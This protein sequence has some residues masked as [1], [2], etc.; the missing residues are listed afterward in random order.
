[1]NSGEIKLEIRVDDK[2]I[3]TVTNFAQKTGKEM[4]ELGNK[5][6]K[7]AGG[8]F[9]A[10]GTRAAQTLKTMSGGLR[11]AGAVAGKVA[12]K[13]GKIGLGITAAFGAATGKAIQ[14]AI[15][16]FAGFESAMANASTLVDTAKVSMEGL[17][18]GIME[19]PPSLG[20]ATQNAEA[21]YQALSAG[22]AP[23]ES[24]KF[25]GEAAKAAKAGLTDTFT[26]VDA[27]TTV[28]NAFGMQSENAGNIFDQMFKTVEQG[29]T[30]F[31]ELS[32]TIGRL[33]P[34]ASAASVSTEEMFAS[35]ATLTKGG[36]ATSEAV[37][38][39]STALGAV[40]KPSKEASDLSEK[41]GLNFSAT[42]LK[43]KGLA[44]FLD[45]VK[46]ATGGNI[47][48]MAQ[49]FGGMESLSV[50]LALTGKQSGEFK[51]IL[52]E[53]ENAA[54]SVDTAFGKQ[55]VTLS[56]LWETFK[57]SIG[58]QA[59]LLGEKLAPSIKDVI[60]KVSAWV[61][62]NQDLIQSKVVE[63]ANKFAEAVQ[64]GI[65]NF[66]KFIPVAETAWEIVKGMA[67]GFKTVGE[68][69]GIT[70]AKIVGFVEKA[71]TLKPIKMIFEALIKKSPAK[72]WGKA[73]KE[74]KNDLNGFKKKNTLT[75]DASGFPKEIKK[76]SKKATKAQEKAIKK[77]NDLYIKHTGTKIDQVEHWYAEQLDYTKKNIKDERSRYYVI[78]QLNAVRAAK[79]ADIDKNISDKK[80]EYYLKWKKW[81]EDETETATKLAGDK[82]NAYRAMYDD[83]KGFA[84]ESYDLQVDLIRRQATEYERLTGD[85]ATA[86]AWMNEKINEAW[87]DS[88]RKSDNFFDGVKAGFIDIQKSTS[89]W[90][91]FGYNIV[92]TFADKSKA[93]LSDILFDAI[94]G[95]LG[96]LSTYWDTVWKSMTRTASDQLSNFLV[97]G[98]TDALSGEGSIIDSVIGAGASLLDDIIG[99]IPGLAVGAWDTSALDS[100]DKEGGKL[101]LFHPGEM[102]V[103]ENIAKQMRNV[104]GGWGDLAATT[105]ALSGQNSA[106]LMD[107]FGASAA[108]YGSASLNAVINGYNIGDV[109]GAYLPGL[110]G[111]SMTNMGLWAVGS[112]S[113]W[114]KAG[115]GFGAAL[116]NLAAPGSFLASLFGGVGFG[117]IGNAIGDVIDARNSEWMWD[118][119]ESAFGHLSHQ[120]SKGM[121]TYY[122][123]FGKD[124]TVDQF[125][126]VL[127]MFP[128]MWQALEA[129][130][131][132][133]PMSQLTAWA[134]AADSE[135]VLMS[136]GPS[137]PSFA[138]DTNYTDS[139]GVAGGAPGPGGVWDGYDY[140]F[141]A[142]YKKGT[143]LA[144]LPYTGSFLGHE[145]EIIYSP[146]KSDIIRQGAM[147][148]GS[149]PV[150]VD[151]GGLH[152]TVVVGGEELDGH[153][154][155]VADGVR[156]KAER[157][158]MGS[159]A[160]YN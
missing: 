24:V 120:T 75:F 142:S 93:A 6:E 134:V 135:N 131:E 56:S 68:A 8:G 12:L 19:L 44:G 21:L 102:V 111:S 104:Y 152:V 11:K 82:L 105:A 108:K 81:A 113:N 1:M 159:E 126:M 109:L 118:Y 137:A 138:G 136:F 99:L 22:V 103:P 23:A 96:D 33:S 53:M 55:K 94:K 140:D 128:S 83:M 145:G 77:L 30:T 90:G 130:N 133:T 121:D 67:I 123:M 18:K 144:G 41:L 107:A 112:S 51:N 124:M 58:K 31:G 149:G 71:A 86:S 43:S 95:D 70:A 10:L 115:A 147:N 76:E 59:I 160:L 4:E 155:K 157:R 63:F 17:K 62:N 98:V 54:G 36:F 29:K 129:K 69:I 132:V 116:G 114:G 143:G 61:E 85:S 151:L 57:N 14:F 158:G 146:E 89:T 2:G 101:A 47:E 148:G 45:S 37:S 15:S 66:D 154:A 9:K 84:W 100:L 49:L 39:M 110:I 42:A 74:M 50:M 88:A 25:V 139:S 20:S 125:N 28:L 117:M 5:I 87:I 60:E 153:I 26:A 16:K 73:V 7:K 122:S 52:G 91:E 80:S 46:D 106:M 38:R 150:Y 141:D 27:G 79:I 48:K 64:W 40:I 156:V 3:A 78:A 35:I 65:Q 97:S 72:P 127:S 34:I 92:K 32:G 119:Y 13:I